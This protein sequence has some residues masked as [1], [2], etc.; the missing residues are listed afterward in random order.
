MPY[1][2]SFIHFILLT[3]ILLYHCIE[4]THCSLLSQFSFCPPPLSRLVARAVLSAW[5]CCL[6]VFAPCLTFCS[7]RPP[8]LSPW[9]SPPSSI[10]LVPVV[11]VDRY[12][13]VR[14]DPLPWHYPTAVKLT[15]LSPRAFCSSNVHLCICSRNKVVSIMIM[16]GYNEV[17]T[18]LLFTLLSHPSF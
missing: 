18:M 12:L 3:T 15:I 11:A 10:V 8:S 5:F 13:L 1:H 4:V 16:A 2:V 17:A 14:S 6:S 7:T 9:F